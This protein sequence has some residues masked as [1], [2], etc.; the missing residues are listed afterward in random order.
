[1]NKKFIKDKILEIG[2]RK[3]IRTVFEDFVICAAFAISNGAYFDQ[4]KE[5]QYLAIAKKYRDADMNTFAEMLGH[6]AYEYSKERPDDILGELYEELGLFS[7]ERGQFFTPQYICDLM[8]PITLSNIDI[9]GE[10]KKKGYIAINDPACGSGRTLLSA[11]RYLED[12]GVNLNRV[13][14]E[15]DDISLFCVC[16][17]YLNLSLSGASGVVKHQDTTTQEIY[18]VFYTPQY[19]Y[20]KELH[21]S[22]QESVK[23]AETESEI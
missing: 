6:L 17:T 7:K 9:T 13:Y 2:S 16:M 8:I 12:N 19:I 1:M 22:M 11:L 14:V 21:E 3:N 5:D 4:S 10:L 15:G 20:N 23:D 18:S